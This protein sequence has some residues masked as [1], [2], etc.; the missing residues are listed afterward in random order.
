MC[1]SLLPKRLQSAVMPNPSELVALLRSPSFR[2]GLVQSFA[3]VVFAGVAALGTSIE[4]QAGE[5]LF[6]AT[7]MLIAALALLSITRRVALSLLLVAGTVLVL[8]GVSLVKTRYLGTPLFAPDLFYFSN[9]DTLHV[10]QQ[11]PK[12]WHGAVKKALLAVLVIALCW[13]WERPLW[14]T[15]TRRAR[16]TWRG[17]TAALTLLLC[18]LVV[19]PGGPFRR[20]IAK[21]VWEAINPGSPLTS[22]VLSVSRMQVR[23]PAVPEAAA[24]RYEWIDE[25]PVSNPPDAHVAPDIV[26]VLEESTFDPSTLAVCT[27]PACTVPM[28]Q[29]DA[30]TRAHGPLRV[31]T[32]GGGTWTSEFALL[33]G[34][35]TPMFGPG[36]VYAPY[37]LANRI[38]PTLPKTL[39]AQGYRTIA[40]YPM[41]GSF[42]NAQRA[43]A[44][45]GFDE[46]HDTSE[47]DRAWESP[48]DV[49]FDE[50]EKVY[51]ETRARTDQP[52]FFMVLTM[53][54]HGPHADPY[55]TLDA[56]FDKPLFTSLDER[57]GLALSNYLARLHSSDR[58][59]QRL[60]ER[61]FG[62][63][64]PVLLAH[65]GDHQPSFEGLLSDMPRTAAAQRLTDMHRVTYFALS[66]DGWVPTS[67]HEYPVLD[68][69]FLGGL[70]LDTAGLRKDAFFAANA[71]LRE[72]CQG[73]YL[74]CPDQAA[75]E[76]YEAFI[77]QRLH[78]LGN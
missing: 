68:L 72:H 76:S 55:A 30:H 70:I 73:R 62:G 69:G 21:D 17:G 40:V 22:F 31:H 6:C 23:A 49:V 37:N 61:L 75:L 32:Y 29:G 43:Y 4:R 58:A 71:R 50:F 66:T 5:S 20:V 12:V 60:Q 1:R 59:L 53:R 9:A 19:L 36:G 57:R 35:P 45:Y 28:L 14:N 16:S 64:R 27:I 65:F 15:R 26:V 67:T 39:R 8:R 13:R 77:F 18:W 54:Q 46:F 44:A 63:S 33:S 2:N 74:D 47:F 3:W 38:A 52:L 11:Y 41:P 7:L 56:P 78:V 10:L 48:D 51:K 42:V 24:D 34:I 25:A